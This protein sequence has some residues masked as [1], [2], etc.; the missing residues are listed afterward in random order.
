MFG[1]ED[2]DFS[3]DENK[4]YSYLDNEERFIPTFNISSLE[5]G[6]IEETTIFSFNFGNNNNI[7]NI[8]EEST[9]I[10]RLENMIRSMM[11][12][13]FIRT[14]GGLNNNEEI[15]EFMERLRNGEDEDLNRLFEQFKKEGPPPAS[16]EAIKNL[17]LIKVEDLPENCKDQECSICKSELNI[18][19]E[20]KIYCMPC[21]HYFHEK[22]LIQWLK[23]NNTCPLCRHQI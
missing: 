16:E 13:N 12:I 11:F 21:K 18:D 10:S 7:N 22:C 1:I 3:D 9:D 15:T 14:L 8:S 4:D 2:Y 20:D 19:N 5:N 23:L 17:Q 6:D